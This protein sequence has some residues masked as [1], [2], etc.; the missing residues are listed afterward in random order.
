MVK[1]AST[2]AA[3][4]MAATPVAANARPFAF[5]LL[6]FDRSMARGALSGPE[7]R[8]EQGVREG[9]LV[10]L[11]RVIQQIEARNPGRM[12][13]AALEDQGRPVYRVR[14]ATND[15]RRLDILVDAVSG[16]ILSTE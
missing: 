8:A 2:L 11:A 9:R 6:Q 15:G 13:D 16:Q 3:L 14:W 5:A 7:A 1:F 4:V 10:P 12:L